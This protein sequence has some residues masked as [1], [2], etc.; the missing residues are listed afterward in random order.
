MLTSRV[1]RLKK[2]ETLEVTGR[3]VEEAIEIALERLGADR[4]QVE[5]DVVNPGKGGILGFGAEPALIRVSLNASSGNLTAIAQLTVETLI[6]NMNA[7][8]SIR[9]NPAESTDDRESVQVEISGEDS[10]LLIGNRGETLK[11]IQFISSLLIRNKSE[12]RV[13]IDVEGYRDRRNASIKAL[14]SKVAQ[15]VISTGKAITLEPMTPNERR[16][17]HMT[18]SENTSVE[19]ESTGG[20]NDRRVTISPL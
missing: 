9:V 11:A 15:R 6:R 18:L 14:A 19:T 13:F 17:V 12:G 20:G 8:A 5:I 7:D 4:D 10:G 3:S 16:V 2:M 1:R